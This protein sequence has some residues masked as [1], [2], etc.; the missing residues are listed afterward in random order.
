M[1]G[2]A[3]VALRVRSLSHGFAGRVGWTEVLSHIDLDLA[4]GEFFCLVGPSGCGKS[5]LLNLLAGYFGPSAG[6]VELNGKPI[7]GPSRDR[8]VVFQDV[9]NSLFPWMTARENIEFGLKMLR[10][11]RQT[12]AQRVNALLQLVGL[13]SH[14]EKFPDE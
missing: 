12:R 7:A 11:P 1:E 4:Q 2:L 5:T 6:T 14:G 3:N 10:L 8:V 13:Q 9:H